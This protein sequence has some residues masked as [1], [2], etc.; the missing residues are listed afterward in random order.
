MGGPSLLELFV[1]V[2]FGGAEKSSKCSTSRPI[3]LLLAVLKGLDIWELLGSI[4]P[5]LQR[6]IGQQGSC[7]LSLFV[8]LVTAAKQ[9]FWGEQWVLGPGRLQM[10]YR[11]NSTSLGVIAQAAVDRTVEGALLY[12]DSSEVEKCHISAVLG[13]YECYFPVK[14]LE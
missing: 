14:R 6:A 4:C 1:T 13:W 2:R 11:L 3:L 12:N 10:L 9:L 7:C 5:D 8:V